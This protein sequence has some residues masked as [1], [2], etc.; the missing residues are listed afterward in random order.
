MLRLRMLILLPL[1]GLACVGHAQTNDYYTRPEARKIIDNII[2]AHGGAGRLTNVTK[3]MTVLKMN[4]NGEPFKI[5]AYQT[6]TQLRREV[7]AGGGSVVQI[8]DGTNT[9]M[10]V[11]GRRVPPPPSL[12]GELKA[13]VGKGV[14]QASLVTELTDPKT[15]VTYLGEKVY[16]GE[17]YL[18]L[19]TKDSKGQDVVNHFDP[20]TCRAC[21]E[22]TTT[23]K[24]QETQEIT[25]YRNVNGILYPARAV[26][27]DSAGKVIGTMEALTIT[28][29]FD[30]AVFFPSK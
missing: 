23:G 1:V 21:V 17:K 7:A 8:F 10:L 12:P 5:T 4:V 16:R 15:S 24:S 14:F 13:Q 20:K 30:A 9:L 2:A 28:N 25:A 26:I 3:G 11:N 22:V 27:R 6:R 29:N 19:R 18:A